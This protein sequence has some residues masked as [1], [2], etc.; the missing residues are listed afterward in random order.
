M[1]EETKNLAQNELSEQ[2]LD[3]VAGGIANDGGCIP[4]LGPPIPTIPTG[5]KTP[6]P[7]SL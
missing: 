2:D 7:N 3:N 1:S 4:P 5:P 6:P